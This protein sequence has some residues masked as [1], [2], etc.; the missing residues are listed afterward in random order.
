MPSIMLKLST[1]I[2]CSFLRALIMVIDLL[3][4]LSLLKFHKIKTDYCV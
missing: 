1:C 2:L 3:P 4:L